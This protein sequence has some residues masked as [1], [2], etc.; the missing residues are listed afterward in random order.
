MLYL[1]HVLSPNE[2]SF[3]YMFFYK[4]HVCSRDEPGVAHRAS[5][6]KI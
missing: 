6:L 4:A 2:I 5:N 1:V 3:T